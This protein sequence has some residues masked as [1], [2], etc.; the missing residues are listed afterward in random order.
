[1]SLQEYIRILKLAKKPTREE[2]LQMLKITG[3]GFIALGILGYI[4]QL[5]AYFIFIGG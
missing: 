3:L 4:F 2:F 1:M 5:I